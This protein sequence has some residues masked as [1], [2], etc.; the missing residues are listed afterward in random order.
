MRRSVGGRRLGRPAPGTVIALV[1]VVLAMSG[2]AV[3]A[4]NFGGGVIH[5]CVVKRG[6][7]KGV[8]RVVH[9]TKCPKGQQ[10]ITFNQEGPAGPAGKPGTPGAAAAN[11]SL[12]QLEAVHFIDAPGEPA[13]EFGAGDS[14]GGPRAGFYKDQ[15]GIVHLQGE[16]DSDVGA[17]IFLLPP[18]FRPADQVC[19]AASAFTPA[20]AFTVNR[21]C[22]NPAGNIDNSQGT[23]TQYISLNALTFRPA[24]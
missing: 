19:S 8:L 16:V 15:L 10:A 2:F 20:T 3:A 22:V 13:F 12:P 14:S 6:E 9:A 24:G 7:E 18:G 11:P 1:A 17:V 21:V 5:G 4:T 23:G